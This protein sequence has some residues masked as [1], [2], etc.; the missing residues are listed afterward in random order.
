MRIELEHGTWTRGAPLAA[1]GFAAVYEVTAADGSSAVAKFIPKAP[2]AQ[3]ELLIGDSAAVAEHRN[4]VPVIDS[5]EHDDF[6][7]LVMPRAKMSLAQYLSEAAAPPDLSEIVA[8]LSDIATALS[9]I[10]GTVVHRDL[11]PENVLLLDDSWCLADFGIA[12][13]TEATTAAD[14][15]K[16]SFT[17]AYAAPEQWTHERTTS[18]TDIYAF[19]VI[20]YRLVSGALPFPGPDI[21]SYR[22]QHLERTPPPLTTGATRLQTLIEECLFKAP[23]SRPSAAN[24]LARLATAAEEPSRPGASR[25]EQASHAEV[26]RRAKSHAME[27]SNRE[28]STRRAQLLDAARLSFRTFWNSLTDTIRDNAPSATIKFGAENEGVLFVSELAGARLGVSWPRP[29]DGWQGPFDVIAY[30]A[31]SVNLGDRAQR[32]WQG[33]SHSLWYCDA[34][35]E[36]HFAWYETAFMESPF[37]PGDPPVEP[38][39]CSPAEGAV[40]FQNVVGTRQLAWPVEELDRADHSEFVDRWIGWFADAAEQRLVRP[41]TMPEKQPGR[42]WRK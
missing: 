40:A 2:G 28:D 3:R 31:V 26:E 35:T 1:G 39:S 9:G 38:F 17:P 42:S 16:F 4:V 12:R 15:R 29:S 19:G 33:R 36:G 8:I 25:L 20:A 6:W 30:A 7:V 21:Y 10:D 5:G 18:A 32:G 14:T 23:Q 37:L 27:V 22:Q 24:I 41:S 34:H 11:K 13:Y